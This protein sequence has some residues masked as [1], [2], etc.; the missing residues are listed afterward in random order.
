M[1]NNNESLNAELTTNTIIN[2]NDNTIL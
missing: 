1:L 2:N